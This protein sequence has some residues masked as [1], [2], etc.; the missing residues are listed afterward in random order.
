MFEIVIEQYDENDEVIGYATTENDA[1]VVAYD[2]TASVAARNGGRIE[3]LPTIRK[4]DA[5]EVERLRKV[6][7]PLFSGTQAR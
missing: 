3:T 7:G 2:H 6:Y 4:L 5:A 1:K